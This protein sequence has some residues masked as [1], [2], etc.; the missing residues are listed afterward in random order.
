VKVLLYI[1]DDLEGRRYPMAGVLRQLAQEVAQLP[2]VDDG[3][4]LVR[5]RCGGQIVQPRTGRRRKFCL[6]CSPRKTPEKGMVMV[7]APEE[8]CA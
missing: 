4:D 6:S 7:T 1:A 8:E 3:G 5:C 2:D